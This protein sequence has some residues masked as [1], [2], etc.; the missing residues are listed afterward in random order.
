MNRVVF[1]S[2]VLVAAGT[3]A[4]QARPSVP[5]DE[6][7][8]RDIDRLAAAGLIDT[9]VLGARPFSER[10]VVRLLAEAQ[11]NL[12]RN[13]E[14]RAWAAPTIA[15]DLARWP[16]GDNRPIDAVSGEVSEL[17]SPY[18]QILPDGNGTIEAAI[19]PLAANRSG[20]NLADG[21]T[22]ATETFHSAT[23]G[24][25]LALWANPRAVTESFRGGGSTTGLTLHTGGANLLFGNASIAI[26][27]DYAIFG[28]APSGGLLLSE[29]APPLD[30]VRVSNDAPVTLP[31]WFRAAGPIRATLLIADLGEHDQ[32]HPHSKLV[33]YHVAALPVR[34][35]EV[36][37]EVIDAMG[38]NGGQ[39]ASFGDR[40]LDAIPIF[41]VLRAH[42]DFQFSNKM[43]G[44]DFHWRVPSWRGFELYGQTAVD[45]FDARRLRSMFLE[46]GGYILGTAL[47]CITEC[48]RFGIRAEYRQTGIRYYTHGDYFIAEHD[49]LLGDPLGPR[50]LGGYLT[51]DGETDA[52]VYG[53]LSGAFEVRSGNSYAGGS[54]DATTSDFHFTQTAH[55]PGEKRT[56]LTGMVST[57]HGVDRVSL[58]A[59][60]GVEHV[61]DFGFV[62]GQS[63]NNVLATLA[64]VVRP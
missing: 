32:I 61:S 45:D 12:N 40:V 3:A 16:R 54:T 9:L 1:A 57:S 17:N 64:I 28:Q 19:N 44:V 24:S 27:R 25:H 49:N 56:R 48:G 59:I 51:I 34:Q 7:V 46:D 29:N 8:Y 2:L 11:R 62:A 38:G 58:R 14:A 39:P 26:G 37:L 18:R 36:G 13:A 10:E 31:W 55:R 47:S 43:A 20:R 4:A 50:G 53:A 60:V 35:F 41:D 30:M 52:G 33:A 15:G 42:S 22:A 5:M 21:F 6:R 63:R 23:L